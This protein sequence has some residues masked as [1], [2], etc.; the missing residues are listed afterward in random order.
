LAGVSLCAFPGKKGME[1]ER[2][3]AGV[4][5]RNGGRMND[6]WSERKEW[7]KKER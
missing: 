4:K 3:I 5:E 2:K 6:S 7:R 1:E